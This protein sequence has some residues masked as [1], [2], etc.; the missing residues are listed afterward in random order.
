MTALLA[1]VD[2]ANFGIRWVHIVAGVAWLGPAC[3]LL[4][5]RGASPRTAAWRAFLAGLVAHTA[6]LH[7]IYVVTVVYGHASPVIGVIAPARS[8]QPLH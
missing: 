7:W 2:F 3:L 6:V 8:W 4:G 1:Q 5:L